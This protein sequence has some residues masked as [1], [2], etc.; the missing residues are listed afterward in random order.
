MIATGGFLTA[1]ECTEFVFDRGQRSPRPLS[2]L[3]ETLL[4]RGREGTAPLTQ[5]PASAPDTAREVCGRVYVKAPCPSVYLS[6]CLSQSYL[7]TGCRSGGFAAVRPAGR[8]YRSIAPAAAARRSAANASSV[9]LS[10]DVGSWTV[11]LRTIYCVPGSSG[12]RLF[13]ACRTE[14]RSSSWRFL[15]STSTQLAPA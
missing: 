12:R 8:I 7:S 14:S 3:R 2:G 5:I 15:R 13:L 11:D 4:L 10:A 6:V 9:T 1:L